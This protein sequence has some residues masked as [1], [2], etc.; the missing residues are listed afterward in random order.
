MA[1]EHAGRSV[2]VTGAA[3]GIGLAIARRFVRA[4]AS[5]V[6]ADLD[7]ARLGARSRR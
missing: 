6:M 3:R 5:V 2:I 1:S 4:G 7:D